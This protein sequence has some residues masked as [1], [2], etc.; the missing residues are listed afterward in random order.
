MAKTRAEALRLYRAIYRAAGEMPTRDRINYVR[1]RLRHEYDQARE[2]TNPER[3]SFLLRL[4]ETQLDT[5]EV[6]AQH[7]KSTFSSPDYHR[8]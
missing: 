2:E 4:A 3:I 6:Q 8:T 7:L 1:R 5:V